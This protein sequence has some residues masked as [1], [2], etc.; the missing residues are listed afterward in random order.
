MAR[1]SKLDLVAEISKLKAALQEYARHHDNCKRWIR[2][3]DCQIYD[4]DEKC[5]CGLEQAL[6]KG[7]KE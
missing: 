4:P 7:A 2:Y 1:T 6:K 3:P 5:T